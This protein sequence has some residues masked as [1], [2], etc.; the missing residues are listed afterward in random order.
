MYRDEALEKAQSLIT[1]EREA[2]HGP[3]ARNAEIIASLWSTYTGQKIREHDV[4]VMLSLMKV[5]RL[6]SGDEKNEDHWVD[7]IG[8]L[9]LGVEQC[10]ETD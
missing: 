4:W 5:G 2:Q 1:K 6:V 10:T 8:Y 7:A 9:A 3:A